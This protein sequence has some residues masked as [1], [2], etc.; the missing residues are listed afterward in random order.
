MY[1]YY[2]STD[3]RKAVET[4]KRKRI[5]RRK[6]DLLTQNISI[7]RDHYLIHESRDYAKAMDSL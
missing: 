7:V 5:S 4:T 1:R 2:T 3:I 6:S